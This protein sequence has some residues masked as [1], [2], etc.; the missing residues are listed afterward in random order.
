MEIINSA[1]TIFNAWQKLYESK[2]DVQLCGSFSTAGIQVYSGIEKLAKA[3]YKPL[4]TDSESY[5]DEYPIYKSFEFQGV[6]FYQVGKESNFS[7]EAA[8]CPT[9]D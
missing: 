2:S 7:Q 6:K 1:S 5:S 3:A 4:I 9:M 8:Q